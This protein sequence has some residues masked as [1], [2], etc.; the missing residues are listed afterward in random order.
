MLLFLFCVCISLSICLTLPC[1][2]SVVYLF[3]KHPLSNSPPA[4]SRR[5]SGAFRAGPP[6]HRRPVCRV[7]ER[8]SDGRGIG[9]R[10]H[11]AAV[12]GR[13]GLAAGHRYGAAHS[14]AHTLWD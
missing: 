3:R 8:G 6:I 9:E 4:A 13:A 1:S 11:R 14:Q 5:R 2:L 10:T 7:R 12:R